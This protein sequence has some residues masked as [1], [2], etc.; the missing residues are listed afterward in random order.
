[1]RN[2]FFNVFL[3]VLFV[4]LVTGGAI[5]FPLGVSIASERLGR[6]ATALFQKGD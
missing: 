5:N 4:D 3:C 2:F 6:V 1:M